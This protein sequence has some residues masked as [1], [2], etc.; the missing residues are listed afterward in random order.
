MTD[1]S[2]PS[3]PKRGFNVALMLSV[4]G[5]ILGGFALYLALTADPFEARFSSA[6][7]FKSALDKYDMKTP[8]G[9][10]K[11]EVEMQLNRDFR[12]MIESQVAFDEKRLKEQHETM[13]VEDEVDFKKEPDKMDRSRGSGEFK[14]LF[15]SYKQNKEDRKDVVAMEKATEGN[16][17]R[18]GFLSSFDVAKTNK[19]LA[20][21][22]DKWKTP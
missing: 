12:A 5:V 16:L 19:D 1:A 15:I 14:I 17:W 13:K 20:A 7:H 22:M 18:R 11:A 21:K 10:A 2:T 6:S 8:A 3:G 9:A 4:V